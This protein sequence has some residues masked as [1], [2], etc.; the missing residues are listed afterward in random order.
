MHDDDRQNG[1]ILNRREALAL[2]GTAG[3]ALLAARAPRVSS[4]PKA[5]ISSTSD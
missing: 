2:L 3:A 1:R 4:R 5:R